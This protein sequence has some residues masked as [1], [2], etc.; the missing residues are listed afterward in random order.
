MCRILSA[1]PLDISHIKQISDRVLCSF[2]NHFVY[3]EQGFFVWLVGFRLL[4]R[5]LRDGSALAL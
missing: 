1:V 2:F 4:A 5:Q 3:P